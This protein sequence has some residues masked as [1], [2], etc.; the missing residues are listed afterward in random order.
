MEG[1]GRERAVKDR[2]VADA[3]ARRMKGGNMSIRGKERVWEYP[4]WTQN[5]PPKYD[6]LT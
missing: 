6:Q 1:E 2:Q 5:V 3:L 4:S